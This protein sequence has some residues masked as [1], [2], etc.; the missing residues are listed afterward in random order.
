MMKEQA[1]GQ[2][3]WSEG[4]VVGSEEMMLMRKWSDVVRFL[5]RLGFLLYE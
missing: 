2:C 5:P 3:G 4:R 1:E